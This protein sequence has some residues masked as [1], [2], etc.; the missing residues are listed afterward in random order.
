MQGYS[1][2]INHALAF[3]AK[4]HA[5]RTPEDGALNFVEWPGRALRQELGGLRCRLADAVQLGG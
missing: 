1:D 5:P 3:A 2:R 4:H